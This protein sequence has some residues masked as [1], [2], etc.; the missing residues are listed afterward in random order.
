VASTE[1]WCDFRPSWFTQK[2]LE[3][4][5]KHFRAPVRKFYA[6][7]VFW[8]AFY[9]LHDTV[10]LYLWGEKDPGTSRVPFLQSFFTHFQR[11]IVHK[12]CALYAL[13]CAKKSN[14][15]EFFCRPAFFFR[16]SIFFSAQYIFFNVKVR[17]KLRWKW[18]LKKLTFWRHFFLKKNL[19]R[20]GVL[21]WNIVYLVKFRE[22]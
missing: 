6:Q 18:V 20:L 1:I 7:K 4:R 15:F 10:S 2:C 22:V 9:F 17:K 21:G 11:K 19:T 8:N 13:L 3:H 12:S 16:A 5:G 14:I